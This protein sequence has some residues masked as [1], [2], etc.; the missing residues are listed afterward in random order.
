PTGLVVVPVQSWTAAQSGKVLVLRVDGSKLRKVGLLANPI[1]PGVLEDGLGIQRSL[2]ATGSLWTVSSSG[3][4]V[5]NPTTLA[6]QAWI[7]F[8]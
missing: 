8:S 2:F 1:T 6:R 3:I 5:S 7:P 4:Q